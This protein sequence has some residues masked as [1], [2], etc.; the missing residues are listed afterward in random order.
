MAKFMLLFIGGE[1]SDKDRQK[2]MKEWTDWTTGLVTSVKLID[3]SPFGEDGKVLT[4]KDKMHNYDWHKDSNVG[5]YAIIL[6]QDLD[7]ATDIAKTC[8]HFDY[9]G[10]VE[11][12]SLKN[13][14]I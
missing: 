7:E 5:G 13:I 10:I 1:V 3:G 4:S 11:V 12:R 14:G 6:A 9:K 2:N 8:P